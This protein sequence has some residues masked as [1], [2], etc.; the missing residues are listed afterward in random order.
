[1]LYK[2]MVLEILKDRPHYY[3]QL[4][5]QRMVLKTMEMYALEL[6]ESHEAWKEQLAQA[7]PDSSEM[8]IASQAL[9]IALKE[10]EN[11]L[12]SALPQ[13]ENELL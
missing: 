1:M 12:P 9:E 5:Q 13:E 4:R 7:N 10:L 8:L 11:R 3:E 2:T 6:K